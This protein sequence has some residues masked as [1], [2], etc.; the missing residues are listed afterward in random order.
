MTDYRDDH[1]GKLGGTAVVLVQG[2]IDPEKRL[3][4]QGEDREAPKA[5]AEA[6]Y[7]TKAAWRYG[8]RR[9]GGSLR[10][11]SFNHRRNDRVVCLLRNRNRLETCSR[12][13]MG[14]Q[15]F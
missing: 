14:Q 4:K 8:I 3:A 7:V 5:G 6:R 10:G 9:N 15:A 12:H 1:R 11:V 2:T 13:M